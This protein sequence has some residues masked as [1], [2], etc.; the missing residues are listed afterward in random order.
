MDAVRGAETSVAAEV[1]TLSA[2]LAGLAGKRQFAKA[3]KV[4]DRIEPLVKKGKAELTGKGGGAAGKGGEGAKPE[5]KAVTSQPTAQTAKPASGPLP[6]Q[7]P[8][9]ASQQTQTPP[10]VEPTSHP[11][12]QAA[13]KGK[14][15]L[16]EAKL[17]CLKSWAS[18]EYGVQ[19]K[20]GLESFVRTVLEKYAKAKDLEYDEGDVTAIIQHIRPY[21]NPKTTEFAS[22]IQD[23][24]K[25]GASQGYVDHLLEVVNKFPPNQRPA[26]VRGPALTG[27]NFDTAKNVITIDPSKVTDPT[28]LLDYITFEI[29]NAVQRKSAPGGHPPRRRRGSRDRIHNRRAYVES[30]KQINKVGS[31]EELVAA[32][33]SPRNSW[34]RSALRRPSRRRKWIDPRSRFFPARTCGRRSGIGRPSPG[35]RSSG[36][37]FG[38]RRITPKTWRVP[39]TSTRSR[40]A[41]RNRRP[42][43]GRWIYRPE[44]RQGRQEV[45]GSARIPFGLLPPL[46]VPLLRLILLLPLRFGLFLPFAPP[47]MVRRARGRRIMQSDGRMANET[48]L[49]LRRWGTPPQARKCGTI[50]IVRQHNCLWEGELVA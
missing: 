34:S 29:Q 26:V 24:G 11:S 35:A 19:R 22:V 39:S 46:P 42:R 40:P 44:P 31:I 28:A 9:L 17:T 47:L 7:K 20:K 30:L 13:E 18:P 27:A 10:K 16:A 4:L 5:P 49:C 3:T 45:P 50:P 43:F 23:L 32:W 41:P 1:K 37:R 2:E 25:S 38:S 21:E 12:E 6:P 36:S 15:D 8:P 48:S 33:A 14:V